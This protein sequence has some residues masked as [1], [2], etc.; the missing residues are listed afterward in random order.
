MK[1]LTLKSWNVFKFHSRG[2]KIYYAVVNLYTKPCSNSNYG[3][4][5]FLGAAAHFPIIIVC[6]LLQRQYQGEWYPISRFSGW[7][8]W[9]WC[10]NQMML[11]ERKFQ[12]RKHEMQRDVAGTPSSKVR[13]VY[14]TADETFTQLCQTLLSFMCF[15][16]ANN[17]TFATGRRTKKTLRRRRKYRTPVPRR[18]N[19]S[20]EDRQRQ[21]PDARRETEKPW[22][23]AN[24][25]KTITY[26]NLKLFLVYQ[27]SELS[28]SMEA[29]NSRSALMSFR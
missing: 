12:C 18:R 5:T 2:S 13:G 21:K 20:F 19:Q 26:K 28:T 1:Y 15:L 9:C 3:R 25:E 23:G 27:L 10:A 6:V 11:L 14:V 4:E 8:Q 7:P 29:V 24:S 17:E 22:I 16:D